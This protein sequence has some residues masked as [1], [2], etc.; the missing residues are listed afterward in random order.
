MVL[1]KLKFSR[2][3]YDPLYKG[4]DPVDA[5][6]QFFNGK[7]SVCQRAGDEP[8]VRPVVSGH[9]QVK[10]C[11]DAAVAVMHC[12]PVGDDG[13]AESPFIPED[14]GQEFFA[15][16]GVFSVDQVVGAHQGVR[17]ALLYGGLVSCEVDLPQRAF[18]HHRVVGHAA[19]LLVVHD[20]M[21][22]RCSHVF[23]LYALDVGSGDLA[24]EVGV[25]GIILEIPAAERGTLDVYGRPE[26]HPDLIC[27]AFFA[28]RFAHLL[29]KI[30][31]KGAGSKTAGREADGDM[32][33]GFAFIY[34]SQADRAVGHHDR[35]DP[36]SFHRESVPAAIAGHQFDLLF[37]SQL[38][39][40]LG[41]I[42]KGPPNIFDCVKEQR[43]SDEVRR[44]FEE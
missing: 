10:T 14:V 1:F 39:Y 43:V 13:S 4:D 2:M 16:A 32:A 35:V 28:Q 17:L 40:D 25:F 19:V 37:Q 11:G 44:C 22:E 24:G 42:H 6:I 7:C 31:V 21:L 33:F 5:C 23:A 9:F 3:L 41:I 36:K 20:V 34:F 26:D 29:K 27:L 38:R 8:L 30:P 18:V 12:T 15:L